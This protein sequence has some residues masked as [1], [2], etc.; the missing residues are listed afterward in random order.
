MQQV[1]KVFQEIRSN[2]RLQ[3]GGFV[4]VLVLTADLGARWGE[5]LHTMQQTYA[6]LQAEVASL[7]S[8]ARNESTMA[9]ALRDARAASDLAD[10]R[11]WVVSSE[12]VGQ[13]RLKDWLV[14]LL[15][16]SNA[17]GYAVSIANPKALSPSATEKSAAAVESRGNEFKPSGIL[18]F[19]ATISF[20]FTPESLEKVLASTEA[21]EPLAKVESLSVRRNERRVEIGLRVL[22]RVKEVVR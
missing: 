13:A 5:R 7:R 10:A 2:R 12:A 8:Q 17:N 21:G 1:D 11:L 3:W 20:V 6:Q 18:E 14:E 15:K 4:I 19:G 16:Q 9:V 22:M